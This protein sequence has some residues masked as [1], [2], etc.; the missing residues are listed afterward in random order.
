M[1]LEDLKRRLDGTGF[2]VAYRQFKK[3]QVAPFIAYLV[4]YSNN[5]SA[6]GEVYARADHMQVELYTIVKDVEA[7][8][9]VENALAGFFWDKTEVNL[10]E[11]GL[12]ETLYEFEV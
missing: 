12:Y 9:K 4:A 7:E 6:D 1:K 8:S 11:E 2:P 5:F 10:K 3:P